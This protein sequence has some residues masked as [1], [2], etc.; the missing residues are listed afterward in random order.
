MRALTP[1]RRGLC[2][3][4]GGFFVD[5]QGAVDVAV[6][7]HPHS[8]HCRPGS[9][10]CHVA[11]SAVELV[12]LRLDRRTEVI[13]H[14]FGAP[15]RLGEAVV[16]L[17]PAG[18]MLGAAQVRIEVADE[19][20]VIS[21]DY[22]RAVDDSAE[23]FEPVPC[24]VFVTEATF[25]LPVYRW[26]DPRRVLADIAGWWRENARAGRNAVLFAYALGKAQRLLCGLRGLVDREIFLHE[27]IVPPTAIYARAGVPLAA[28]RPLPDLDD[29]AR[30]TGA[31]V[32]A[33][34]GAAGAAWLR[35][36]APCETAFVSGWMRL[37]DLRRRRGAGRGFVLSDH[38]DWPALLDTVR[39]TG[40]REIHVTHGYAGP[41]ARYLRE[42]GL[43]ATP[44]APPPANG[45]A[46]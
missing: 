18:H 33:P 17:H 35:R 32:I 30:L 7:T 25:A 5:P 19:V 26:P 29:G 24:D 27:A 1:H 36:L 22:R 13:G 39:A 4:Q 40:A 20:C 8:D 9:R 2:C 41:F 44:L 37:R 15:F 45:A 34:P 11:E 43:D 46:S 31:L 6:V 12:R 3:P 28:W 14:R 42:C 38:A 23:P 16:S 21:G 10:V